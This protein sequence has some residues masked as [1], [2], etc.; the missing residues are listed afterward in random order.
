MKKKKFSEIN[1]LY[2]YT[3]FDAALNILTSKRLRYGTLNNMNDIHENDKIV[4]V[5]C[6]NNYINS[7]PHEILKNLR[8]E[9]SKYRQIS[10]ST[11]EKSKKGF[12]LH[13]MWGIYADKGNGVCFVFDKEELENKLDSKIICKKVSYEENVESYFVS[14]SMNPISIPKEIETNVE[15]LF[16]HKRKEWE[17]EQ[18]FRILKRCCSEERNEYLSFG[19]SLKYII[20]SSTFQDTNDSFYYQRIQQIRDKINVP[21]LVYGNGLF[22]YF[23]LNT[24]DENFI[25]NSSNEYNPILG[26]NCELD[27]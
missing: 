13:Q 21:I 24:N 7:F 20:I 26:K 3:T 4:F 16:F 25:W 19:T 14:L 8:N 12:D 2:H 5:D 27:L 1:K 22:D 6:Q 10:F 17:H 9:I 18:E 11:D 15:K 23:L